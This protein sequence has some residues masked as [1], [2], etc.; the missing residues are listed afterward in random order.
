VIRHD[1]SAAVPMKLEERALLQE[2]VKTLVLGHALE[3][4]LTRF[5]EA[6][7]AAGRDT[8]ADL[9]RFEDLLLTAARGLADRAT[10]QKLAVL[11]AVED[12]SATVRA[13]FE[14][15]RAGIEIVQPEAP[16]AIAA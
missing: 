14:A 8:L 10:T 15:V 16:S 13:A 11:V 1:E 12:V 7:R 3:G 4:A 6:D 5:A 2:R 9:A